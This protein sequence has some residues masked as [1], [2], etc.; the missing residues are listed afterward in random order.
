MTQ[1]IDPRSRKSKEAFPS[2][3]QVL[4]DFGGQENGRSRARKPLRSVFYFEGT[5]RKITPFCVKLN[6]CQ[7]KTNEEP[8]VLGGSTGLG[9]KARPFFQTN[10][11]NLAYHPGPVSPDG[12]GSSL[13]WTCDSLKMFRANAHQLFLWLVISWTIRTSIYD[14]SKIVW[15]LVSKDVGEKFKPFSLDQT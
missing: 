4:S 1:K 12:D 2:H 7:S 10:Q 9:Y 3:H 5:N 14:S 13:H 8:S 15:E 6:F 11:N